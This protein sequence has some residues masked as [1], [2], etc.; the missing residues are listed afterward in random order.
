MKI[1][2]NIFFLLLIS[3]FVKSQT[4]SLL[5][6]SIQR[7]CYENAINSQK[8]LYKKNIE[9]DSI[10]INIERFGT[11]LKTSSLF[12]KSESILEISYCIHNEMPIAIYITEPSPKFPEYAASNYCFYFDNGELISNTD[13]FTISEPLTGIGIPAD[14][15][16]YEL[17]GYNRAFTN[18]FLLEYSKLLF[19]KVLAAEKE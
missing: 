9:L 19:D 13:R 8:S 4:D 16:K 14:K 11:V 12:V 17:F 15:D 6:D 18:K 5:V 10:K 2:L 7:K 3:T 1:I